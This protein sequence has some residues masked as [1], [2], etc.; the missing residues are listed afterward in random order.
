MTEKNKVAVLHFK[1]HEFTILNL[2]KPLLVSVHQHSHSPWTF[3][4]ILLSPNVFVLLFDL[5][6]IVFY[7]AQYCC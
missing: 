2:E 1:S 6:C 4:D 3:E 5:S 7:V